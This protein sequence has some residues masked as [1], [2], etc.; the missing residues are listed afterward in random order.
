MF[1]CFN[2]LVVFRIVQKDIFIRLD[3]RL[4]ELLHNTPNSFNVSTLV[5]VFLRRAP[6]VLDSVKCGKYVR[7]HLI[8]YL[9]DLAKYSYGK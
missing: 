6:E 3:K 7:F 2:R 1:R 9:N 4:E 5:R 8:G